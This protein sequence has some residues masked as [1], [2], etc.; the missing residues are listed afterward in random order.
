MTHP[1]HLQFL[2]PDTLAPTP[3]YAQVVKVTG[4]Q[5]IYT[6][7]QV[8][9]DASRNLVGRGDFRAQAQQVFENLKAALAAVGADFRHVV[10]L[11]MYVVDRT[12]LP[13]LREVRDLYVNT[14]APPASTTVE[15]RSLFRE[16]FL[17]E[18]EAIASLPA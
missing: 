13:L 17:L 10:K 9:L 3:G 5:M 11:N 16:E 2:I 4:G 6:A 18:I 8:A 1:N 7:G 15:V 12:H 14:Q